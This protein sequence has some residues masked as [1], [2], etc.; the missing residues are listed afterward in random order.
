[1]AK[2]NVNIDRK[3]KKTG[4]VFAR[5]PCEMVHFLIAN[6]GLSIRIPNFLQFNDYN[7]I[8]LAEITNKILLSYVMSYPHEVLDM[9]VDCFTSLLKEIRAKKNGGFLLNYIQCHR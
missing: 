5:Y 2:I 7:P 9:C 8:K 3:T 6:P 1:M 4:S